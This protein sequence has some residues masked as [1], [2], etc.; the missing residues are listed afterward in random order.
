[1]NEAKP[2]KPFTASFNLRD[3]GLKSVLAAVSVQAAIV[4]KALRV[5]SATNL[6]IG[7]RN[8]RR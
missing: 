2:P 4:G 7:R 3:G 1:M 5:P 6:V 8:S